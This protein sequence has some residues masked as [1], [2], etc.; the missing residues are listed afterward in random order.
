M[1]NRDPRLAACALLFFF[2]LTPVSPKC[3][4]AS[5]EECMKAD[6]VPGGYMAGNGFDIHE[7]TVREKFWAN[8]E[9]WKTADGGCVLCE[10]PLLEGKPLQR[11]PVIITDWQAQASCEQKVQHSVQHSVIAVADALTKLRVKNDWRKEL[12]VKIS[13][14]AKVQWALA[15]SRSKMT[16]DCLKKNSQDKYIFLLH[17]ITCSYY[18]FRVSQVPFLSDHFELSVKTLP[19]YYGPSSKLKYRDLI[20]TYGTHFGTELDLGA[21]IRFLTAVP[22]CKAVMENVSVSEL[23]LCLAIDVGIALGFKGVTNSPDFQMCEE[24]KK[25]SNFLL[26]LSKMGEERWGGRLSSNSTK[27]WLESAK[28]RPAL[29]S[30]S[31]E[32]LHALV[33]QNGPQRANLQKAVSEYVREKALWKNCNQPCPA[34]SQPSTRDFC[35][36]EC[37]NNNFTN[38]MCCSQ[39]R[40]LARMTVTIERAEGLWGDYFSRSDGYVRVSFQ[41]REMRTFTVWNNNNPTWNV[42]FDFGVIH[43][44]EEFN[45]LVL[46]VMDEDFGWNDDLLGLCELTLEPWRFESQ[47]CRLNLGLLLFKYRLTCG[48]HLHG[49]SCNHYSFP[50]PNNDY[51]YNYD[52]Y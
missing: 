18:K 32:P 47:S 29:L 21:H 46:Q 10:N 11:L 40:G 24:K 17:H 9:H 30:Y 34:G 19:E 5:A 12:D 14:S 49:P 31:L 45:K 39:K 3:R 41:Q 13:P 6:F 25:N 1:R 36:C 22:V 20:R 27:E 28:S 15:G 33:D 7:L 50:S 42:T 52:S 43:L 16:Q 37:P 26:L 23:S 2:L 38:S 35:S 48:P 8:V 44:H 51:Y 4:K